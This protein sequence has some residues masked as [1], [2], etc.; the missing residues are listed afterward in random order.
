MYS[1]NDVVVVKELIQ[2]KRDFVV[3]DTD[4]NELEKLSE[5]DKIL[6]IE[7]VMRFAQ[8]VSVSDRELLC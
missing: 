5:T 3:V 4:L 1:G 8:C 2:T 7:N 6:Y